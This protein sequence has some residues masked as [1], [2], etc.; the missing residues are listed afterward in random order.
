M[1]CISHIGPFKVIST[2]MC[3]FMKYEGYKDTHK[4][5]IDKFLHFGL[6]FYEDSLS[7]PNPC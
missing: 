4:D 7:K 2:Y 1:H 6:C 5:R 3:K